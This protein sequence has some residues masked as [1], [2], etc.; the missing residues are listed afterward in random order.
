MKK[1]VGIK[2]DLEEGFSCTLIHRS[3]VGS[4]TSVSDESQKYDV[5]K[6]IESNSKLAVALLVMDECFLPMVD[7][8]S[9]INL[10]RN[11]VYNFGW[12]NFL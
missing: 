3:D 4:S 10:I 11:I 6:Q 8:R 7:N 2:H 12:V 9:G 5:A 1:L